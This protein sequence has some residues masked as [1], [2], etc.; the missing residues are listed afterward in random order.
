MQNWVYG[1]HNDLVHE[2]HPQHSLGQ[3]LG[4]VGRRETLGSKGGLSAVHKRDRFWSHRSMRNTRR[5]WPRSSVRRNTPE[6]NRGCVVTTDRFRDDAEAS[7]LPAGLSGNGA[8]G[9]AY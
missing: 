4:T 6:L 9:I 8:T 3:R 1:K 7:S 5:S 2:S